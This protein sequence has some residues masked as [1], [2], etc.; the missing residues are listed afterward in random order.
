MEDIE[1]RILEAT[2]KKMR[3]QHNLTVRQ[4]KKGYIVSIRHR[5]ISKKFVEELIEPFRKEAEITVRKVKTFSMTFGAPKEITEIL[6]KALGAVGE[7]IGFGDLRKIIGFF[8]PSFEL[9]IND[10]FIVN[11]GNGEVRVFCE[12]N[13]FN[14]TF[15]TNCEIQ[16][17]SKKVADELYNDAI[18]RSYEADKEYK[19][20]KA[21]R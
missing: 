21:N 9:Q 8:V 14:M 19:K 13:G 7:K 5:Q 18:D 4:N 2:Q 3:N 20:A 12:T 15:R 6:E 10:Y 17:L 1:I 16:E 11:E